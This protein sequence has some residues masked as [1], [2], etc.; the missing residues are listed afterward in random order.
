MKPVTKEQERISRVLAEIQSRVPEEWKK[1]VY[2]EV[3]AS[4]TVKMVMEKAMEDPAVR[5]ELRE[6]I[7]HL[8]D[9]GEFSKKRIR[10]VK[11]YTTLIDRFVIREINKAI[12]EGRLPQKYEEANTKSN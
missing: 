10:E 9:A 5:P 4:P 2:Q 12:R 1:N 6:K 11:K 3:Y 8:Y 7:K